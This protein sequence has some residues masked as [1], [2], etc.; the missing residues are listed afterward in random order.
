VVGECREAE[1]GKVS[2]P[3]VKV[4]NTFP[5][6]IVSKGPAVLLLVDKGT[7]R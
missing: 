4:D 5:M 7:E 6:I 3:A 1:E 2:G